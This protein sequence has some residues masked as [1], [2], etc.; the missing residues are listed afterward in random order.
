MKYELGGKIIT[1]FIELR[2]RTYSYLTDDDI[3]S[4]KAKKTK[5]YVTEKILK[6]ILYSELFIQ[7]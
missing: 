4:K 7:C 3:N 6:H 5:K 1:E 2:L